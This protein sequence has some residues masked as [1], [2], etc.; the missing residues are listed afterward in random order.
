MY[1]TR[2]VKFSS[3]CY[4]C[5]F[6]WGQTEI[7]LIFTFMLYLFTY[8]TNTISAKWERFTTKEHTYEYS[9]HRPN[10]FVNFIVLLRTYSCS[11]YRIST[12]QNNRNLEYYLFFFL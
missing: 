10:Y 3:G 12:V 1:Y 4:G 7:L 9:T 2:N 11:T 8:S 5:C 6:Q